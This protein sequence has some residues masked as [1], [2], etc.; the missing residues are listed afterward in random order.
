MRILALTNLYPSA[1]SA[2]TARRLIA[3]NCARWRGGTNWR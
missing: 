1:A 3:S 2:A